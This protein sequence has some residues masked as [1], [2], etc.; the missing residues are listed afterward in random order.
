MMH[1]RPLTQK[2]RDAINKAIAPAYGLRSYQLAG[3]SME[4]RD[5]DNIVYHLS[6]VRFEPLG[7]GAKKFAA[8]LK[9]ALGADSIYI[10]A[11]KF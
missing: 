9:E 4:L 10:E 6:I 1:V 7:N 11:V 5:D 8:R 2:E 3:G